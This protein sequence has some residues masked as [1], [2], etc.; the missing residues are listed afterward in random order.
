MAKV[1]PPTEDSI[2]LAVEALRQGSIIIFPTE[3]VYGIGASLKEI[4]AIER[5]FQIKGR[6]YNQPFL[7]H[8]GAL[9]QFPPLVREIS[10]WAT[11]LIERLWPGPVALIFFR[12]PTIPDIVTAGGDTVGIRMVDNP[13]FVNI[14]QTLG[15]PLAGTSANFS[16]EPPTNDFSTIPEKLL[17]LVEIGIDAGIAGDGRPSTIIDLTVFPPRLIREGAVSRKEIESL[18]GVPLRVQ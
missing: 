12:S 7:V 13:I 15:A 17:S 3:T 5:V 6:S 16:G 14:T 1:L 9:T 4:A 8:C 10:P 18:L 11:L 2:K